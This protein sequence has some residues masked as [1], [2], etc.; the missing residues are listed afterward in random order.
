MIRSAKRHL[1][2]N[3]L[4]NQRAARSIVKKFQPKEEECIVEI[5]PGRGALTVHLVESKAIIVAIELDPHLCQKLKEKLKNFINLRIINS[6][7]LNYNF[8]NIFKQT[9]REMESIRI[10]GNIPYQ[11]SKPILMKLFSNRDVIHD[12][13]LM[14]QKE[15]ADRILSKPGTK[16]YSPLTVLFSLTSK[17]QKVMDLSPGSFSPRP[18]VH[19]TVISCTFFKKARFNETEEKS[20]KKMLTA[21]FAKRRKT[22]KNNLAASMKIDGAKAATLI[23]SCGF[24]PSMRAEELH[25]EDILKMARFIHISSIPFDIMA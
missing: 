13:A 15:V 17:I 3:F 24:D 11:I 22:I 10:I 18:Q 1:G 2:Q 25:P 9:G 8:N 21:L 19:S 7:I 6:D 12:A 20:L 5:G 23:E 14:L 16:N 4:I